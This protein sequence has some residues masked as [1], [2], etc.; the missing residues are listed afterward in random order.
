MTTTHPNGGRNVSFLERGSSMGVKTN[1]VP[2]DVFS[3]EMNYGTM[4][5]KKNGVIFFTKQYFLNIVI[6]QPMPQ[7]PDLYA[8]SSFHGIGGAISNVILAANESNLYESTA[9]LQTINY[10]YNIRGWLTDINDA[11]PDADIWPE[12]VKLFNLKLN[13]NTDD[14]QQSGKP[15]YNGNISSVWWRTKTDTTYEKNKGY[16]YKYDDLNRLES[17]RMMRYQT[18]W[19]MA[20][21]EDDS[22]N[23]VMSYDKNGNIL[24]LNR[25]GGYT[26]Q[27]APAIDALTYT[28]QANSNKLAKVRDTSADTEGFKD[29]NTTGDD[30]TYDDYGNLTAD[31]NKGITNITYN[32]L[33]LPTKITFTPTKHIQ[34]I[35]NA[36]GK[37]LKKI[38]TNGSNITTT[39]YDGGII[40]QKASTGNNTMQFIPHAEGYVTGTE[41][42]YKYIYQYKDHLGNIRLS[43]TDT[44][45]NGSIAVNEI[46]EENNYY[47]FG[48]K[49]K[50]YN[51][52]VLPNGNSTAQKYKFNGQEWQDELGLNVTAM[53]FRQYDNVLGRFYN[54]DR[55][56]ELAPGITPY[57]FGFN[58]PVYW[59]DPTGLFET[60]KEARQYRRAHNISGSI[61]KNEN[62][63]FSIIHKKNDIYYTAGDD[64]LGLGNIVT[65]VWIEGES[66]NSGSFGGF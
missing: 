35:Y 12:N 17:A 50:G 59:S 63:T 49:H 54:P 57:R 25:T 26:G 20:F 55:L 21:V 30:Y 65:G 13:Y 22:Y 1:Y 23:E 34:Y 18:G 14:Y 44:D 48:L 61:V 27:Q 53:D 62:G 38:V 60:R 16:S 6:G 43:Y 47:P 42:N 3:I 37:K 56:T 45:N 39:E 58:N 32:H 31:K 7:W 11:W 10:K 33:S 15:L 51:N 36:A 64:F 2:G 46:I 5:L 4:H 28:Y 19:T 9:A 29:G 66:N 8:D 24:Q 52:V 41:G 40:Y